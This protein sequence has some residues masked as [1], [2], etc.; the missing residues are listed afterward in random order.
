MIGGAGLVDIELANPIDTFAGA[1]GERSAR[2]Y[3]TL[4]YSTR[5]RK[6]A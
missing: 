4:G 1:T 3:G 5:A 2:K 6:P